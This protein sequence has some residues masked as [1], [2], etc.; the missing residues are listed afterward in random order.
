MNI[1][2]KIK[3]N[4]YLI[5]VI[6]VALLILSP[7]YSDK[8]YK[9]HDSNY[10]INVIKA[11]SK[12]IHISKLELVPSDVLPELAKDFGYGTG[13][14]YP[15]L[16]HVATTYIYKLI[17]IVGLTV[18]D[19]MKITTIIVGVLS[20]VCIYYLSLKINKNKKIAVMSAI[21][22][23][24]MPYRLSDIFV[25]DAFAEHFMFLFMPMV[26]LGLFELI[27]KNYKK[28]Y[29]LFIIGYIGM[30]YSHLVMSLFFTLF[31]IPFFIIY[32]K[33][34]FTWENIKKLLISAIIILIMVSTFILPMLYHKVNGHY[35][36]FEDTKMAGIEKIKRYEL[37]I[38][39]FFKVTG[40]T[41]KQ[42]TSLKKGTNIQ[43]YIP[44]AVILFL[45]LT[46]Y[47]NK[48]IVN[49]KAFAY[50][51]TTIVLAMFM[52]TKLCPW[53]KLPSIL[54]MI[55]FPWRLETILVISISII[56][57]IWLLNFKKENY[58]NILCIILTIILISFGMSNIN[59]NSNK[60]LNTGKLEFDPYSNS[61]MGSSQEY[62]PTKT[63]ENMDYY[64]ERT[65]E[66]ISLNNKDMKIEKGYDKTP[67]LEFEVKDINKSTQIELPRLFYYGYEL[68][69][70]TTGDK[71]ALYES[72]HGFLQADI[73]T[74]GIYGL[75]YKGLGVVKVLN[76]IKIIT[77]IGIIIFLVVKKKQI[78]RVR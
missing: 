17:S 77:L 26:L 1:K 67:K 29:L 20:S 56:A 43:F 13:I 4:K 60:N 16:P 12:S 35:V 11:Y 37:Q 55:Q 45:G 71:I 18:C 59:Y 74:N 42:V 64:N 48:K 47:Y 68:K 51:I 24:I 32:F 78:K 65:D 14:F 76:I 63:K 25:R 61:G 8:Y 72:D 36:V 73:A 54:Y 44:T 66:V 57:P 50:F 39:D 9:G 49:K 10:H 70:T 52:S 15:Q 75:E 53:D 23:S 31:L 5:I 19:A 34:I 21:I 62:L 38:S 58:F 3:E 30:I 22:F 6:L 40:V 69:N 2:K 28:F 7:L 41:D 33:K 27:D 46:F